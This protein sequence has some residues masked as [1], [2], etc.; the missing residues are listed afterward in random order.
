MGREW[1]FLCPDDFALGG[2]GGDTLEEHAGATSRRRGSA[3]RDIPDERIVPI[4]QQM[5]SNS[6]IVLVA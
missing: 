3:Y 5:R 4:F 2:N 1:R 6:E